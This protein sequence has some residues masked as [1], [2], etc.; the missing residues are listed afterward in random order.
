[1]CGRQTISKI[2]VCRATGA[3][4]DEYRR[5]YAISRSHPAAGGGTWPPRQRARRLRTPQEPVTPLDVP[6]EWRPFPGFGGYEV[7]DQGRVKSLPRR[8]ARGGLI[9]LKVNDKGYRYVTLRD[10]EGRLKHIKVHRAV[11]AAFIGPCP[12]GQV[13]RHGLGGPGDNR[14]SNLCYGT[15]EENLA[16]I[17]RHRQMLR[18]G[19]DQGLQLTVADALNVHQRFLN[20]ELPRRLAHEY[21]TMMRHITNLI[22]HREGRPAA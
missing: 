3:C 22:S 18:D 5:R 21:A 6:E 7:S 15:P 4:E 10:A 14:V 9:K 1:V 2:G 11:A 13:V 16:D 17:R 19:E 8:H 20:D 12:P